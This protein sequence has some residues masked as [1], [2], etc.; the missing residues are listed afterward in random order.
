MS[1]YCIFVCLLFGKHVPLYPDEKD[2]YEGTTI[3]KNLKSVY[4]YDG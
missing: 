3:M 1:G 2:H 4:G